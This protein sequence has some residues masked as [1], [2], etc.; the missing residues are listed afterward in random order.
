MGFIA[1]EKSYRKIVSAM[2]KDIEREIRETWFKDHIAQ[3]TLHGIYGNLSVL[4]WAKPGTGI[5]ATRYMFDQN[6]MYVTGDLGEAV[7]CFSGRSDVFVQS[8]YNL[9]Y[10]ESKMAAYSDARREYDSSKALA[11]LREWL[12]ELKDADI[13]YDHNQV[14][15]LIS[16]ALSCNSVSEWHYCVDQRSDFISKLDSEYCEW[17]YNIGSE[18][19][20]RVHSYLIGL[21][22]A[23]AQLGED[24]VEQ[25][26]TKRS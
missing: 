16:D 9:H 7:F 10:F 5:F 21:Q 13:A 26:L 3:Y 19:P 15:G 11:G 14:Q 2:A 23:A 8:Q 22:M 24:E 12:E 18:I 20:V 1:C 4:R 17:M 6:K 25:P